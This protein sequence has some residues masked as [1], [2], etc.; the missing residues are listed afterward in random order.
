[1]AKLI[2]RIFNK[3]KVK[4]QPKLSDE[5]TGE[6]RKIKV[7]FP[8]M[9]GDEDRMMTVQQLQQDYKN[10]LII[11]PRVGEQVDLKN[12]ANLEDIQ[13]VVAMPPISGG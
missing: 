10:Y 4:E 5:R 2:D 9:A 1:M 3:K 7:R 8:S 12:L 11:D 13:E 6:E